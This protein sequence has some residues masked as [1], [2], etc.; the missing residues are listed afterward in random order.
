MTSRRC[1]LHARIVTGTGG[2]P[3]KTIL[4]SPRHLRRLG[5]ESVVVYLHPPGDPGFA[6]IEERARAADAE[7]IGIP[8]SLPVDPRALRRL[9]RICRERGVTV[10]HGH[11]YKSNLYG[12]LLAKLHRMQL[13][14]TVHGWVKHTSRTPLYYAVDRWCLKR[15]ERVL[16][17]S[18]D[19]ERRCLEL[20][21]R[22]ERLVLVENAID[23]DSFRRRAARS[24]TGRLRVGAVGR[25][26]EEKGFELL[27]EAVERLVASG[28][29][30]ELAI[31]GEGDLRAH[32]ERRVA[33]SPCADRIELL[34]FRADTVELFEGFDVFC[35]SSLREGLPN[36]VLEAMAME[37]PVLATRSG[38]MQEF[39]RDGEDALLCDPGSV[40]ELEHGLAR[41]CDDPDLR[42]RL[43][44]NARARIESECS[45]A[46]RMDRVASFYA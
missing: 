23:T 29:D 31:A 43:A 32:L 16:A 30:L 1:V 19:L 26:S 42:T 5:F 13:V 35:L 37:V 8:E 20:G 40:D 17:V 9:L 39:A 11:D 22:R 18:A 36:V 44:R 28:R 25:L 24:G 41:L 46:A 27:I 45:F 33:D 4:N 2:G 7:L 3:E 6:V 21:V 15:Y 10:W 12:V 38:G 34:G 14:T